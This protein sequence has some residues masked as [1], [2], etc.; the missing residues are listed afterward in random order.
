MKVDFTLPMSFYELLAIILAAVAIIIP[1][2]QAIWKKWITQARLFFIST[3]R[4]LVYFNQ[5]GSYIRIDGV[6]EAQH[7]PVSIKKLDATITRKRDKR[8]LNLSWSSFISPINQTLIGNTV[9]TME[10]AHPF[11]I[12]ADNV[13]CAFTEF[14]DSFDSF[15]K[16]FRR[17]TAKLFSQIP[18]L[19]ILHTDFASA[20]SAYQSSTEYAKAKELLN[21]EFMWEI[22]KYDVTISASY[23][24]KVKQFFYTFSIDEATNE[25]LSK[26]IEESLVS[27]LKDAYRVAR[28]YQSA[29]VELQPREK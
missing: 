22:G 1:I 29:F 11:R 12:D 24:N 28:N 2:V 27:P 9:Q 15:G 25:S 16:T 23:R 19:Q 18:E 10:S 17:D 14:G 6:F 20:L 21:K 4:A 26:N 7:K 3:G 13:M 8:E 5:S